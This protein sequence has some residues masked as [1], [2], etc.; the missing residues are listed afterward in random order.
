MLG[1]PLDQNRDGSMLDEIGGMIGR[2]FG[3]G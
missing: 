1:G 3:R 2:T